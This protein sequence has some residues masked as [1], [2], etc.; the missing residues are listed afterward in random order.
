MSPPPAPMRFVPMYMPAATKEDVAKKIVEMI[1]TAGASD[2]ALAELMIDELKG[3]MQ[4]LALNTVPI[5]AH[6]LAVDGT[7]KATEKKYPDA[8]SWC[9]ETVV[10]FMHEVSSLVEPAVARRLKVVAGILSNHEKMLKRFQ[11]HGLYEKKISD[12]VFTQSSAFDG[13]HRGWSRSAAAAA[14]G[15]CVSSCLISADNKLLVP[16]AADPQSANLRIFHGGGLCNMEPGGYFVTN[17]F[18]ILPEPP[19]DEFLAAERADWTFH[20]DARFGFAKAVYW[21]AHPTMPRETMGYFVARALM[22]KLAMCHDQH[23]YRFA[24]ENLESL[25]FGAGITPAGVVQCFGNNPSALAWVIAAHVRPCAG[26]VH[27]DALLYNIASVF[28]PYLVRSWATQWIKLND[29][30]FRLGARNVVHLK[31]TAAT[32]ASTDTAGLELTL[33]TEFEF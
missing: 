11:S 20:V 13:D 26:K 18:I 8:R 19:E 15:I 3:E 23:T 21:F 25:L 30:A 24:R 10:R 12:E 14:T 29:K 5:R 28:Y 33:T 2:T 17:A 27:G 7:L 9:A 16:V 32:A 4:D 31:R 1:G 6:S 22:L